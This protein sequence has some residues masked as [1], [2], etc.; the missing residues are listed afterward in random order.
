MKVIVDDVTPTKNTGAIP[1]ALQLSGNSKTGISL[2]VAM[3]GSCRPTAACKEYC[4]GLTGPI[5]WQK[6]VELQARNL[7]RLRYLESAP[8]AELDAE[9]DKIA[10]TCK[11]KGYTYLRVNGV[12]DL[13]PGSVRLLNTLGKRHPSLALWVATRKPELALQLDPLP[14]INIMY[15]VDSTTTDASYDAIKKAVSLRPKM[16]FVAYVQRDSKEAIPAEAQLIF[17]EH[18]QGKRAAW[19][20]DERSCP[21]TVDLKQGGMDHNDACNKCRYC[22]TPKMR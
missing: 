13:V 16:S 2:N 7:H 15:G 21:A 4:Y 22:F 20:P 12:G 9:A 8:Q 3:A 5:F 1:P 10:K 14:N 19:T 18:K 6:S 17:N 11:N